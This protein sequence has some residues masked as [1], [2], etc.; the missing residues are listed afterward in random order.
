MTDFKISINNKNKIILSSVDRRL[1][2][3]IFCSLAHKHNNTK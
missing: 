3:M 1:T 2:D